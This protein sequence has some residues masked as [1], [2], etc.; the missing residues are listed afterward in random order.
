MIPIE[1]ASSDGWVYVLT[2]LPTLS[3]TPVRMFSLFKNLIENGIKYN[4]SQQPQIKINYKDKNSYHQF[5]VK[6]NGIGIPKEYHQAVFDLYKRLQTKKAYQ[7]SGLG[8]SNCKKI[9]SSMGGTIWV[10]SEGDHGSTFF[11][12]ITKW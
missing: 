9:V 3:A 8:L 10:E 2:P 7:G 12:T 11:F 4:Q 6:D 1:L 5:S